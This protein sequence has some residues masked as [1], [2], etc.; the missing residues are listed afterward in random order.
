MNLTPSHH[1]WVVLLAGFV[2]LGG[3]KSA[4]EHRQDADK[5][6]L[7][8]VQ[9]KQKQTLGREEAFTIETPADTL[10]RRLLLEQNLPHA[11]PETL[12]V[13]QLPRLKQDKDDYVGNG[14]IEQ[15]TDDVKY[16]AATTQPA[17][18]QPSASTQPT[19]RP[20]LKLSLLDALQIGARSSREYQTRKEEVFRSALE[21]DL[22]RDE[23]RSSF[24]G[25]IGGGVSSDLAGGRASSGTET[26]SD[27]G[28]SQTLSS[29]AAITSRLALD[30]VNLLSG[31]RGSAF[32]ILGD[33][34]IT[35]PLLRGAGRFIAEEALRQ[36]DRDVAYAIYE[37][38]RFKHEFAVDVA[39][40]YLEV[41]QLQDEIR[42]AEQNYKNLIASTRRARRLADAGDV[43]EIDVDQSLQRELRAR[44]RWISSIQ[45][46]AQQL[47]RFKNTL[48]LPTDAAVELDPQELVRLTASVS[49]GI[50]VL[51]RE[52]V[53]AGAVPPADAVIVLDE[54][55]HRGRGALEIPESEALLIALEHRVDLI[56]ARNQVQ[57]AQRQAVVIADRL[58]GQM[59]LSGNARIGSSRNLGSVDRANARFRPER[60]S[61]GANLPLDFPLERDSERNA[62]RRSLIELEQSIREAQELEDEIKLD[63]R[64]ALR[65][66]LQAREGVQIQRRA[67]DVAERRVRSTDMFL[68]AGR[69]EIR[70]VLEAQDALIEAQDGYTSSLVDYRVAELSL[71]RDLG[72]LEVSHD[73]LWREY[74]PEDQAQ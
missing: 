57:D 33:S 31:D 17:A 10:R 2:A 69:A 32:G 45:R 3:C 49:R 73:G 72:V 39:S 25:L 16:M 23:F 71:Q 55:G 14:V 26:T 58:R 56:V 52:A 34:T 62:Y 38:E 19:T 70:D 64:N 15:G 29:G 41:L 36:A 7:T 68:Q 43:P 53:P 35:I 44:D 50:A 11:G 46:Y 12:G 61:Y 20:V 8:I 28:F 66:L 51:E 67:V 37:F 18:T 60:G 30:L 24:S 59:D 54:P 21:L 4:K 63:V 47:D 5:V 22:E 9:Q 48:G 74:I 65:E 42:N 1:V 40:S 27:G 6:A 13:D